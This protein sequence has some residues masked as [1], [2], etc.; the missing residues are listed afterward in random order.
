MALTL[1]HHRKRF[2]YLALL[3]TAITCLSHGSQDLYPDF[4]R[5][6]AWM[7]HER[8]LGM[9]AM[10][11]IPVLYNVGAIAGALLFGHL[12]ERVGRRYSAMLALAVCLI[13]IPAWAFG[14]TLLALV[15][16]SSFMQMGVQGAYGLIPAHLNELSPP[17]IRSL[18]PGFVYQLGVLISSPFIPVLNLLQRHLGYSWA[19]TAFELCTI[20]VLMLLF[21]FGPEHR[22]RDLQAD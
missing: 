22:G 15:L 13:S 3:M 19:L 6:L 14:A 21:G 17:N 9:K 4:L 18:L 7:A 5:N 20:G 12:S 8:V 11:G 2:V 16:G 10:Y 1:L